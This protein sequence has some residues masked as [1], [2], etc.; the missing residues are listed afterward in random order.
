MGT[1]SKV[2]ASSPDL[3]PSFFR[4]RESKA[5][6]QPKKAE[7]SGNEASKVPHAYSLYAITCL[8]HRSLLLL[9]SFILS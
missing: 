2:L 7:K 3:I 4:L 9:G 5:F 1:R 8:A 6:A